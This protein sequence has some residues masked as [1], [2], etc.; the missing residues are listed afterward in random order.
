[1]VSAYELIEEIRKNGGKIKRGTNEVLKAI[2]R[3]VAKLVFYAADTNPK[4]IVK[5]IPMLCKER[6][7]PCFEVDSKEK[8]GLASGLN[9]AAASIAV[10]DFGK[11]EK[12]VA[13]FL[14]K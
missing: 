9:V 10:L 13:D 7:I 8:L 4:E 6:N 14:K 3:G 5:P 12:L 2:E 1:M 11:A